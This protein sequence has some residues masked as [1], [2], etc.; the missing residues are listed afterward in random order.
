LFQDSGEQ[1]GTD[2]ASV[3][4]GNVELLSSLDEILL[5]PTGIVSQI[6]GLP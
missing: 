3:R 2:V 4:I 1:V 5:V 6:A